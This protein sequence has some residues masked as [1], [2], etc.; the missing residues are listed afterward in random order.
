M[1]RTL[2]RLLSCALILCL[3]APAALAEPPASRQTTLTFDWGGLP[4]LGEA[5]DDA[6]E[7]FFDALTLR[8]RRGEG[9]FALDMLLRGVSVADM[10]M[11]YENGVYYEASN[12]FGGETLAFTRDEFVAL[13]ARLAAFVRGEG[14]LAPPL[15]EGARA[16]FEAVVAALSGERPHAAPETLTRFLEA[17]EQWSASALT[18]R[19]TAIRETTFLGFSG[20]REVVWEVTRAEALRLARKLVALLRAEDALLSDA[21]RLQLAARGIADPAT[22][23]ETIA[24]MDSLL[25]SL[26]NELALLLPVDTQP[27]R[28]R[29][30]YGANGDLLCEQVSLTVPGEAGGLSLFAEFAETE[31]ATALYATA[32]LD[33]F[34]TRLLATIEPA[35]GIIEWTVAEGE[36]ESVLTLMH[37]REEMSARVE[38]SLVSDS[39]LGEGGRIGLIAE[40]ETT[41]RGAGATYAR[42]DL[43]DLFVTGLGDDARPVLSIRAVSKA[44]DD[45]LPMDIQGPAILRPAQMDAAAFADW[46]THVRVSL[47]QTGYTVLGRLPAKAAALV[48]AWMEAE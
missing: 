47:A 12:L 18:T 4:A 46:M 41:E 21:A 45:A 2:K 19:E 37:E 9:F 14:E 22:V 35:S 42:T 34:S 11:A 38:A 13:A 29:R 26:P 17:F 16:L 32:S 3:L 5:E 27:L 7:S 24:A 20:V 44:A 10:A 15:S 33:A 40:R 48:L 31:Q 30:I 6:L 36:R 25:A 43:I 8:L 28:L 23:S 1:R 39:L